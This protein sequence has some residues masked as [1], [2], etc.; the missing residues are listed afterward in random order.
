MWN[1]IIGIAFI[2]GGLSGKLAL[3]GT[4]SG[5]ALAVLGAVLVIWGG[6]QIIRKRGQS[7]GS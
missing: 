1:I 5:E 7:G 3:R 4:Q 2:V 6:V